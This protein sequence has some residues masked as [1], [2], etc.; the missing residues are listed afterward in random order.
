MNDKMSN[1][2]VSVKNVS[3]EFDYQDNF[4]SRKQKI[5]AVKNVNLSIKKGSFVGLVGESGSG[6]TTLGR[7]ILAANKITEGQVIFHDEKKDYDL[8]SISKKELKE[9]YQLELN[10]NEI[11]LLQHSVTTQIQSS[12]NQI[13][14]TLNAIKK[15]KIPTKFMLIVDQ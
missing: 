11:I 1:E 15:L 3:V 5:Q 2:L 10:G 13:N 14:N 8:G 6:K 9:K 7:A 12:K 4:L